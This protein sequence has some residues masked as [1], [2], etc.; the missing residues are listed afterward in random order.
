MS[1]GRYNSTPPTVGDGQWTDL[2]LDANGNLKTADSSV[3]GTVSDVAVTD[4][5]DDGTVIGLLKGMLTA[6]NSI[7]T[8]TPA[9]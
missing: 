9:P 6:L 4:P 7:D 1:R 8:K 5:S 3:T 2:Q